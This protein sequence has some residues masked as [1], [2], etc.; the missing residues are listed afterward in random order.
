MGIVSKAFVMYEPFA[1]SS[2]HPERIKLLTFVFGSSFSYMFW[3]LE[4][5]TVV[6]QQ[7]VNLE[8]KEFSMSNQWFPCCLG[9]NRVES[10]NVFFELPQNFRYVHSCHIFIA[11]DKVFFSP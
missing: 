7:T 1:T 4:D 9:I 3:A 10:L 2:K 11:T 5:D 8:S 6:E